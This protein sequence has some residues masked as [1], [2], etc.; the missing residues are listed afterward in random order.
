MSAASA[1]N[2]QGDEEDPLVLGECQT[3]APPFV[4]SRRGHDK[5][6]RGTGS[7]RANGHAQARTRRPQAPPATVESVGGSD[8]A[9]PL[10]AV[11]GTRRMR[12]STGLVVPHVRVTMCEVREHCTEEDLW[13]VSRGRVFD[14][15]GYLDEHPGGRRCLIRRGGGVRDCDE[16]FD[17]HSKRGQAV[18]D[19][20]CVGRVIPCSAPPSG[21]AHDGETCTIL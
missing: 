12:G 15:S 18:W 14:V 1:G 21:V 17:F 9:C 6:A 20:M 5:A 3:S 10:C 11:R 16:D 13:V 19:K 2:P 8:E 4:V 7:A